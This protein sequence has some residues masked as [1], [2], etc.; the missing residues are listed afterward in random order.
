VPPRQT[1]PQREAQCLYNLLLGDNLFGLFWL[2]VFLYKYG[3]VDDFLLL[4]SGLFGLSSL[5]VAVV[6][7]GK[8][9]LESGEGVLWVDLVG[10][11]YARG[12]EVV[13]WASIALVT[14]TDDLYVTVVTL[15]G[16]SEALLL[17]G[18]EVV[19][20]VGEWVSVG[21]KCK[22]WQRRKM[23]MVAVVVRGSLSTWALSV[24]SS[25]STSKT[26]A[27]S[28]LLSIHLKF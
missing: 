18:R 17:R 1:L 15:S 28:S 26:S 23:S 10:I 5:G 24:F 22:E 25:P 9:F 6:P 2:G 13:I 16:V 4:S 14:D 27:V 11:A 20:W 8:A 12:T 3:G 21:S 7:S 19:R